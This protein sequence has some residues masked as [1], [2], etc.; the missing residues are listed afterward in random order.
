M[1]DQAAVLF[2]NEEFYRAF[3]DHDIAAMERIWSSRV[4]VTCIHPGWQPL[5]GRQAV[6]ES[7]AAILA[8]PGAP[9]ISCH[10]QSAFVLAGA[11]YVLCYEKVNGSVL[12]ATNIFTREDAGWRL[13]HH[14][15]GA[16]P[17]VDFREEPRQKTMQ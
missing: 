14:Q 2:V 11:A 16:A 10:R 6:M 15:A 4:T 9:R 13:V 12:V 7:W 1:S 8:N 17:E 5:T 3:D